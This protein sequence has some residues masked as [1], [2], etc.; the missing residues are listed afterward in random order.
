MLAFLSFNIFAGCTLNEMMAGIGELLGL[1]TPVAIALERYLTFSHPFK[2]SRK[3]TKRWTCVVCLLIWLFSVLFAVGLP[4]LDMSRKIPQD[5]LASCSYWTNN[6][7]FAQLFFFLIAWLFS[8]VLIVGCYVAIFRI[9]KKSGQSISTSR[10]H[11]GIDTTV[12][13]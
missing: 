9:F 11:E 3:P 13:A 10:I 1:L 7:T 8:F 4:L 2:T 6:R 5:S 12:A